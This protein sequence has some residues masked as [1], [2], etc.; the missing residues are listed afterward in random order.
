[1]PSPSELERVV[2][3]LAEG[4]PHVLVTVV[5][6]HGSTPTSVGAKMVVTTRGLDRGTVGGGRLEAKAIDE[7]L[8]LLATQRSHLAVEWSLKADVGMTCGGSVRVF[9]E[10]SGHAPWSVV[11]FGAG[12]VTQA[13]AY[14]LAP[15][16]CRVTC[17]DPR[18]DWLAKLPAGVQSLQ[19]DDPP[20]E[21]D[22]LTDDSFV[23]CMTRGHAADLP[24]L[25]RI[26]GKRRR[27]AYLGVIG[28]AAKNA[29]LR[30]EIEASGIPRDEIVFHCPVGLP[31]GS[32]HPAEI[33]VSIAAQLLTVRDARRN[34]PSDATPRVADA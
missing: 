11:V 28:S 34:A 30:K 33:A 9:F 1:M 18:G 31:I 26:F 10:A 5:G 2:E 3:L 25:K 32:N 23:L 27:F 19:T 4:T 8:R 16:P 7:A 29:V 15:M 14:V 22:R 6:V 13:L 24:V 17:I 12:H 21:V 20:A